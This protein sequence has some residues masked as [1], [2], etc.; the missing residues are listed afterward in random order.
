MQR[1]T[2]FSR[3]IPTANGMRGIRGAG[4]PRCFQVSP[5]LAGAAQPGADVCKHSQ[6]A[7]NPSSLWWWGW[8]L[9]FHCYAWL[10]SKRESGLSVP[11][12]KEPLIL[13]ER[14]VPDFDLPQIRA[15]YTPKRPFY[16]SELGAGYLFCSPV[17]LLS[18]LPPPWLILPAK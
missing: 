17:E 1:C 12:S 9:T 14:C 16:I 18:P 5:C 11:E 15:L 13:E 4:A 2:R 8:P 3:T 6:P 7:P 10:F